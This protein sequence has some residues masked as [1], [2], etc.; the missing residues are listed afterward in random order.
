MNTNIKNRTSQAWALDQLQLSHNVIDYATLGTQIAKDD[1]EYVR[2]HFGLQGS[3]DFSFAQLNRSFSL[4]GHHH[5]IMY[6]NGLEIAVTNKTKRIETF[7]INFT[8]AAFIAIG[9]HGNDPLK[10]FTE[11]VVKRAHSILSTTWPTNNFKIQAVI[12]EIIHCAYQKEL[13]DLFLLSKSIE[14]LVLQAECFEKNAANTLVKSEKDK[15]KLKEAKELLDLR[16]DQPPTLIELAKLIGLNEYKL[17]KGFKALFGTTVFGYV[18]QCRMNLA[19]RLLLDTD[20]T[21]KEIAYQIGYSSP[22]HFSNVFKK[23]FG[24]SPNAVRINPDAAID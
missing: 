12:K 6:S 4:S 14:L 17:K 7:G 15:R 9:Q 3:Y 22:Q 1:H 20:K 23:N 21:A 10:R 16:I 2:L 11:R 13:K 8:S 5:N 24:L 19:K 18:H